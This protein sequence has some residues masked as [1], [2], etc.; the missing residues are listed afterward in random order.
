MGSQFAHIRKLTMVAACLG[1]IGGVAVEKGYTHAGSHKLYNQ[2]KEH[3][4]VLT[5]SGKE[6]ILEQNTTREEGSEA[7]IFTY[8][9]Y[10]D[11]KR[12]SPEWRFIRD[13]SVSAWDHKYRD[14]R[15]DAIAYP[16]DQA[17]QAALNLWQEG[18]LTYRGHV[19]S[20]PDDESYDTKTGQFSPE[21]LPETTGHIGFNEKLLRSFGALGVG[22]VGEPTIWIAPMYLFHGES[23]NYG[24]YVPKRRGRGHIERQQRHSA[25]RV[26]VHEA[27]HN[28]GL[29]HPGNFASV[30]RVDG[31]IKNAEDNPQDPLHDFARALTWSVMGRSDLSLYTNPSPLDYFMAGHYWGTDEDTIQSLLDNPDLFAEQHAWA[32]TEG[33]S[34]KQGGRDYV[35]YLSSQEWENRYSTFEIEEGLP[36]TSVVGKYG[37]DAEAITL[38]Y[39][40]AQINSTTD[41][42]LTG[43]GAL[44]FDYEVVKTANGRPLDVALTDVYGRQIKPGRIG[45]ATLSLKLERAL[46][47]GEK[48]RLVVYAKRRGGAFSVLVHNNG[49]ADKYGASTLSVRAINSRS[50]SDSISRLEGFIHMPSATRATSIVPPKKEILTVRTRVASINGSPHDG[51]WRVTKRHTRTGFFRARPLRL[52]AAEFAT[53]E[54]EVILEGVV[55]YADTFAVTR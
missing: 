49:T 7:R 9:S 30:D 31:H 55:L 1:C 39:E 43:R 44:F 25:Q 28:L 5:Y 22:V 40:P 33:L 32:P 16:L 12:V 8:R 34:R 19:E 18:L 35:S 17:F 6:S 48:L 47:P 45:V 50:R 24:R 21:G 54:L 41:L 2:G 29:G 13:V 51:Q 27:G 36:L 38:V 42:S 23:M 14:N 10:L 46:E 52:K 20:G 53:I 11:S 4:Y 3:G 37:S 15:E 26:L